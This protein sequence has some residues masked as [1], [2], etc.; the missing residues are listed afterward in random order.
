[1]RC[2]EDS[3]WAANHDEQ[4]S[5]AFSLNRVRY[6]FFSAGFTAYIVF[7]LSIAHTPELGLLAQRSAA[8]IWGCA[9]A[10]ATDYFLKQCG[11][12]ASRRSQ[13]PETP[14]LALVITAERR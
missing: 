6:L 8:T 7:M 13:R 9:V 12:D 2:F 14:A 10:L 5:V 3:G 11:I 4:Y 1:M